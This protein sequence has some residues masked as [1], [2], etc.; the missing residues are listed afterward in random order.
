MIER[1]DGRPDI[2]VDDTRR[3]QRHLGCGGAITDSAA[4]VYQLLS[5]EQKRE[6]IEACYSPSGLGYNLG[7]ITI[8]SCDFSPYVY[9]YA[10]E[11]TLQDF[12]LNHAKK[13]LF[14]LIADVS[15]ITNISLMASSWSPPAFYKNNRDKCRGGF[16]LTE[17]YDD[18]S[19]YIVRFIASARQEGIPVTMM[20]IQN[21]PLATQIWESCL[22]TASEEKKLAVNIKRKLEERGLG[23]IE[24][25][26]WDHN[27]DKLVERATALYEGEGKTIF[28]GMA[29]HWYDQGV[30]E[31]I[32]CVTESHPEKKIL[33][34]EGCVEW[35]REGNLNSR[36]PFESALRY[37]KNYILDARSGSQGFIDWNILL[38][39]AGGPNHVGNYC[40]API[41]YD[42]ME[43]R[44]IYKSSYD[45]IKHFSHFV[46]PGA[47]RIESSVLNEKLL[48]VAYRN[49]DQS[50]AIIILNLG[51][52]RAVTIAFANDR[53]MCY[54]EKRSISTIIKDGGI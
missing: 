21:E 2:F 40:E 48:T 4:A 18:Y 41:M 54:I 49:P 3:F 36:D 30:H 45:A 29:Y 13:E 35:L 8:G 17:H 50:T 26:G 47:I 14:P 32:G 19:E 31:S 52:K 12:S 27:R 33:F 53:V 9:D 37:A 25:Y 38:N 43:K 42:R 44:I 46:R 20:T 6:F 16:L 39:E 28:D 22:F 1:T 11:A 51:E 23:F 15:K 5:P 10:S 34:T 7:R 24:I